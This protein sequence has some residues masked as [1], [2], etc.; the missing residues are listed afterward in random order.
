MRRRRSWVAPMQSLDTL[1]V[2]GRGAPKHIHMAHMIMLV[3]VSAH[4]ARLRCVLNTSCTAQGAPRC[5]QLPIVYAATAYG[6]CSQQSRVL[7]V[8][9]LIALEIC[10]TAVP[11]HSPRS[12]TMRPPLTL[13]RAFARPGVRALRSSPSMNHD[14]LFPPRR[15]R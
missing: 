1:V 4:V 2:P 9:K 7:S 12:D 11:A 8:H 5:E 14:T 10:I 13:I 3:T 6:Q 15:E